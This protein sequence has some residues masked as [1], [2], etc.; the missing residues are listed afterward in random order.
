MF[1]AAAFDYVMAGAR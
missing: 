1:L